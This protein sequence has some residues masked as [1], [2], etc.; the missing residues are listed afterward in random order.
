MGVQL[1]SRASEDLPKADEA[2]ITYAGRLEKYKGVDDLIAAMSSV[3]RHCPRAKLVI[4]GDGSYAAQAR[5][6]VSQLGMNHAVTF[7][8]HVSQAELVELYK[9]SAVTVVPSTCP[10]TFGKV[11]VEAMSVGTPVI[12]SDVGGV[13]D[14]LED[15]VNGIL[16]PPS[17]PEELAEAITRVL[18]DPSLRSKLSRNALEGVAR[19]SIERYV[20]NLLGVVSEVVSEAR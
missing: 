6:R 4:A 17:Q 10:E 11:G 2:Q 13:R 3:L 5:A 7:V 15:N 16:V 14:W 18:G 20:S 9:K 8:G 1:M 12:A 19:F